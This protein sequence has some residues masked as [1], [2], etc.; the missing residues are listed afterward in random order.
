MELAVIILAAGKGKRMKSDIPKVLHK[1]LGEPMI[2]YVID[3]VKGLPVYRTV[4]VTG[5]KSRDVRQCLGMENLY[6]AFQREQ[7]GTGHAVL[8]ARELLE[9]YSGDILI[10]NGDLPLIRKET[11][12]EL[13]RYHKKSGSTVSFLSTVL[14]N[15]EGYGRI[16]RDSS[17]G[18]TK[19][20]EHGEATPKEKEIK[21]VNAGAYCVD[22][23]FLWDV[24]ERLN[25]NNK[26]HE[27]YLPDIVDVAI[28]SGRGVN[29][30]VVEDSQ[31]VLGVNTRAE[32]AAAEAALKRRTNRELMESGVTI[33][34]P[35]ETYISPRVKIGLD[36]VIYPNTY[37]YG[38]SSIGSGCTIGP[39]VWIEDSTIG[40]D[41]KIK[42]CSSLC[43]SVIGDGVSIGPFAN[44]RPKAVVKSGAKIGNFVE[45]KKS[46]I[47]RGSKVS[48]LSYL[49]D[50]TVGDNVNIG[51]GTIT[52]NYDGS[53][54]HPTVIEDNAFI[55]SDTMLVAP[56][57]IGRGA[58]TG[59]GSTI[60]D[61][62]PPDSLAIGRARQVVIRNW[63]RKPR[64]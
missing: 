46:E 64:V 39:L 48:H 35:E 50:A 21:E 23:D 2:N 22:S 14:D 36:T 8:C 63:Q 12:V 24:L 6:F 15:P 26:Q 58:T 51:A 53:S 41:V 13:L 61:D 44:L 31:E 59:A 10:L 33:V 56:V 18:V 37:I 54:K 60:T 62:V 34:N 27:Y 52:C 5:Y 25:P 11:L 7:L 30:L 43:E 20:V 19:I 45:V 3:A 49:G 16:T 17:G 9:G 42:F 32:L 57:K 1:V 4:V 28:K 47:G 38:E 40:H 29:A 55:G